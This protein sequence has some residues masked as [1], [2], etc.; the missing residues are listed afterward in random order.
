LTAPTRR[1]SSASAADLHLDH[2]VAG[3]EVPAHLV[4]QILGGLAREIPAAA[5][6]AEHPVAHLAAA[7]ALGQQPVQ[8]LLSDLRHRVPDS[9]L[10][11]ADADR[12]LAVAAGFLSL[13]HRG[14]EFGRIEIFSGVVE[15]RLGLGREDARD[16]ARAHLRAAGVA[17]GRIE[18]EAHNRPALAHDVGEDRNHR[19]GHLG[20][21][22]ARIPQLRL[23]RDRGLADVEDAHFLSRSARLVNA[24]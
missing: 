23:E 1:T 17:A 7:V 16:Q 18:G 15:E 20:E 22:E 24:G 11:G 5:N 13:H 6:V 3:I 4:L 21:I 14:K 12:A 10:D 2:G 8:R 19:G 9:N